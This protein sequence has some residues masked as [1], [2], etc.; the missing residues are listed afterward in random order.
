MKKKPQLVRANATRP[1]TGVPLKVWGKRHKD[2][3]WDRYLSA[4]IA[5]ALSQV[6]EEDGKSDEEARE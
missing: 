1:N 2:P 6:D 5:Q 4:L 3:D